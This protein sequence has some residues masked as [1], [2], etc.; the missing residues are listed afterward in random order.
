MSKG[1]EFTDDE[2]PKR[3]W[4]KGPDSI[5]GCCH[6]VNVLVRSGERD[7]GFHEGKNLGVFGLHYPARS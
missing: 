3:E 7:L 2:M 5:N 6:I 4:K 1:E